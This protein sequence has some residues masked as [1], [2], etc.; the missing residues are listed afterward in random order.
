MPEDQ[1]MSH[2]LRSLE[3]LNGNVIALRADV[4]ELKARVDAMPVCPDPTSC[5]RLSDAMEKLEE[6]TDTA[7]A[8]IREDVDSHRQLISKVEG[9]WK[10]LTILCSIC[11]TLGGVA[12]WAISHFSK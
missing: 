6:E 7:L 4:A 2:I 11:I 9:G 8:A 3:T 5:T 1:L 12:Q 10:M